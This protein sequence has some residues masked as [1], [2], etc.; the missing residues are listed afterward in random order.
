MNEGLPVRIDPMTT[1]V[2]VQAEQ[3]RMTYRYRLDLAAAD[4]DAHVRADLAARVRT[5]VCSAGT[6]RSVFAFGGT[7]RFDYVD[8]V[9]APLLAV[10][11]PA[12]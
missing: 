3:T 7:M 1:M 9:G 10:E 2:A 8:R 6:M 11:I 4:L 5:D 12:C